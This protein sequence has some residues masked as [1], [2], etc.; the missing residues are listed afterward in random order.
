MLTLPQIREALA[1]RNLT[2]VAEA[3]GVSY[4]VLTRMMTGSEPSY[5]TGRSI[6]LY[7]LDQAALVKAPL[8]AGE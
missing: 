8:S 4:Y 1:D 7:L 6:V 2:K 3:T 5:S